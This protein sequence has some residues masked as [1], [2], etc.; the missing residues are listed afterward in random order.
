MAISTISN[1]ETL[2][3]IRTKLNANFSDLDMT[4][5]ELLTDPVTLVAAPTTATSTG[6]KGQI[7]IDA[8]YIYICT[9]TNTWVRASLVFNTWA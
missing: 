5:Q 4:K 6:T 1:G 7:A 9:A 3:S 8:S 2:Y